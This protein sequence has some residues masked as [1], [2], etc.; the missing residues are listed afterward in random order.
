MIF[1]SSHRIITEFPLNGYGAVR[2]SRYRKVNDFDDPTS[3]S[4]S[5]HQEPP[6]PNSK[7]PNH[8][9]RRTDY[10]TQQKHARFICRVCVH[11]SF[12]LGSEKPLN[13]FEIHLRMWQYL[14]FGCLTHNCLTELKEYHAKSFRSVGQQTQ[15]PVYVKTQIKMKHHFY[16][17]SLPIIFSS[18]HLL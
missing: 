12:L 1:L 9:P 5:E 8:H 10:P 16:V 6:T 11:I 7:P 3:G 13:Y 17:F 18:L 4:H 14:L 2:T 15:G